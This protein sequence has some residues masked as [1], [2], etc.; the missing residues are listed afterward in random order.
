MNSTKS[1]QLKQRISKLAG[2]LLLAL[3]FGFGNYA[4]GQST[5]PPAGVCGATHQYSQS[6]PCYLNWSF[7]KVS[8]N[9]WSH[10]VTCNSNTYRFWNNLG[11]ITTLSPGATYTLSIKSTSQASYQL[12]QAAW[13]DYNQ[14]GT[15]D[16]NEYIGNNSTSITGMTFQFTVP[17]NAKPG[18]TYIRFRI[19]YYY[20]MGPSYGCGNSSY[21][22]GETMDYML[23]IASTSTPSA[24][25]VLPDTVYTN[26][27]A[28]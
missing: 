20:G 25:F 17:C 16:Q 5:S 10:D 12:G 13:I 26:S 19:D 15:F 2:G 24:N 6:N 28:K 21:G 27:P 22:Y 8:L 7:A 1:V 9:G 11:T 14:N 23:D 4:A 3:L 18:A